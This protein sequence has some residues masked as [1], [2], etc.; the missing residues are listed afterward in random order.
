VK[1]NQAANDVVKG[2]AALFAMEPA[3]FAADFIP[4]GR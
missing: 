3:Q 4:F 1:A 2:T